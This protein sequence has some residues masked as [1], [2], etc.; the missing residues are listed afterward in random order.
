MGKPNELDPPPGPPESWGTLLRLESLRSEFASLRAETTQMAEAYRDMARSYENSDQ[1]SHQLQQRTLGMLSRVLQAID[2]I[3]GAFRRVETGIAD[4]PDNL[5]G[6][7]EPYL[8]AEDLMK[9]Q[10]ECVGL[11]R[12]MAGRASDGTVEEGALSPLTELLRLARSSAGLDPRTGNKRAFLDFALREIGSALLKGL[13]A[14]MAAGLLLWGAR[15][16]TGHPV[17]SFSQQQ[18]Q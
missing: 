5:R 13:W 8:L 18:H 6:I 15:L 2:R 12:I 11:L 4:I 16:V 3:E 10:R 9:L 14:A 17:I 7:V 1:L